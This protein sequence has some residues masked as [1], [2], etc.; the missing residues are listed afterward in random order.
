MPLDNP[1]HIES[2]AS[3]QARQEVAFREQL[4][5]QFAANPS[6]V[7]FVLVAI[8][9]AGAVDEQSAGLEYVPSVGKDVPLPLLAVRHIRQAPLLPCPFV[10]A[11]HAFAGTGHI[12]QEDVRL[13]CQGPELCRVVLGDDAPRC[14][15]RLSGHPLLHVL[16]QD[17]CPLCYRFVADEERAF[18]QEA[19]Q[20][21]ALAARGSTE[22]DGKKGLPRLML[23][24]NLGNIH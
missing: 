24:H 3:V 15:G 14:L 9:G 20:E 6:G 10:L 11:E 12:G 8:E 13:S 4:A 1:C 21:R 18:G 17:L 2:F 5:A 16:R 23:R 19:L 7:V 22:V